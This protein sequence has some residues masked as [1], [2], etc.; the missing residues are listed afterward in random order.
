MGMDQE[1]LYIGEIKTRKLFRKYQG[2]EITEIYGPSIRFC[3]SSLEDITDILNRL[4]S[5]T[6][7][8]EIKDQKYK[9]RRVLRIFP[10]LFS[11]AYRLEWQIKNLVRSMKGV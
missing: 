4:T 11:R 6:S 9:K 7:A 8:I 2:G 3:T 1:I 5:E 10:L